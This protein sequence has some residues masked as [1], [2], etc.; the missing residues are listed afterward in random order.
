MDAPDDFGLSPAATLARVAD[1]TLPA[2][3]GAFWKN[4]NTA[5]R[6]LQPRLIPRQDP[7]PTDQTATHEFESIR[8]VRIGCTLIRPRP[9]PAAAGLVTTHGYE[10][11]PTLAEDAA[12][13]RPI[14]DRG[15]AVLCLRVRGYPGSRTDVPDWPGPGAGWM[16]RGLEAPIS[17]DGL[18]VE[19][20]FSFAVADVVAACRALRAH[21]ASL[22]GAGT[23]PVPLFLH[24]E[25]LGGAL[26]VV[27]GA[28]LTERSELDRLAVALP[29][30]GD[31]TWRLEHANP[32]A[33]GAGAHLARYML[34]H[35]RRADGVAAVLRLFDAALHARRIFCPTLAKLALRDDVV[36]APAAAAVY[37]ALNSDPGAKW[38]FITA[39]GHFDGGLADLRRHAMFERALADFLDPAR[40]PIES[41]RP[42][43][44]DSPAPRA[45]P[46]RFA[47]VDA[48]A[49]LIEA[50]AAAGRTLDDLP[51][52]S[53][54]DRIVAHAGG[55][56]RD[57]LHRLHNLRKAGRLPRLGR[58]P[59]P[60]PL[61]DKSDEQVLVSLV[62]RAIGG[63]GQR[64]RLPLTPE[65]DTI[66]EAF[67]TRTG[68]NLDPH[69]VW[70]LVARLAK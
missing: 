3:F 1:R 56:P 19:W 52:T 33:G 23:R 17:K 32:R 49:A 48:D 21:L 43:E 69:A 39:Y 63:L 60:P 25:S 47:P 44:T 11:V 4:W 14:A 24:G 31:W 57:V 70:R 58:A 37:N 34:D 5:V 50:Y 6:A 20:S 59:T 64:D 26:A 9:G 15:V 28:Q 2:E 53:D 8:H 55:A 12:R 42:W 54:L 65:F 66:V 22:A 16:T 45:A 10:N 38:R 62:T 27:A 29:T 61:I 68:K 13:W 40:S 41:M 18:G 36:P 7:D 46:T 67:N 30:L 35:S 51:Y